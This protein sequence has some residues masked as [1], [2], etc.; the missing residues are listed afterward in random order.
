MKIVTPLTKIVTQMSIDVVS[1]N[2]CLYLHWLHQWTFDPPFFRAGGRSEF[3]FWKKKNKVLIG[4]FVFFTNVVSVK[5]K[6]SNFYFQLL[7]QNF[8]FS[9][10]KVCQRNFIITIR[11]HWICADVSRDGHCRKK[12][13]KIFEK[14]IKMGQNLGMF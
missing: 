4:I 12:M 6:I 14:G 13:V 7:S 3:P 11:K 10:R 2:T 1:A 8:V 9:L 5:N